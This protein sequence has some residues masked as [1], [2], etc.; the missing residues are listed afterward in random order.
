MGAANEGFRARSC[1]DR[2][3]SDG[4]AARTVVAAGLVVLSALRRRSCVFS[5]CGGRSRKGLLR[6]RARGHGRLRIRLRAQYRGRVHPLDR[7]EGRLG[8]DHRFCAALSPIWP[9]VPSAAT[10]PHHRAGRRTCPASPSGYVQP[11]TMGSPFRT[12]ARQQSHHLPRQGFRDPAH[13][14]WAPLLYRE[15]ARL[16]LPSR[17]TW[18]SVPTSR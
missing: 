11:A 7:Q 2:Q 10:N 16:C 15:E 1:R 17:S 12:F 9:H 5:P 3:R 6:C 14:R 13:H 18:C 4:G 8:Q